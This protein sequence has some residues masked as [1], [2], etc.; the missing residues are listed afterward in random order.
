MKHLL[1][2]LST[3]VLLLV[4]S[5][6]KCEVADRIVA[7]V[8][9]DIVTLREVE[10]FVIVEKQSRYTSMNEY[11]RSMELREK[12][13]G[14]IENLLI[15]Q[16]GRKLKIDV[17]D[18][19]VEATVE[20]IKKQNMISQSELKAQLEKENV[21]YED[22]LD[23]LKL[24]IMR[25]RVLSRA[26]AQEVNIDDKRIQ[27]YY[28]AHAEDYA[29]VEYSIQH[30]FISRQRK[31]AASRSREAW[32]ELEKGRSFGD[33]A[34]D[35]SD[36]GSKGEILSASKADLIPELRQ[37]LQIL[38]PG[39][40]TPV[41]QTPYGFHILKLIDVKKGVRAPLEEVK[42]KI[43]AAIYQRESEKR[44]KDYIGK[45]KSGA[46]IEVKI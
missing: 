31:D 6:A 46:Y 7:I 37:G 44:Y 40:H 28:D 2:A 14:F 41:I 25:N 13:D 26:I 43:K 5:I 38:M 19:D 16:Q 36:E 11:V 22:F 9:D 4:P 12:L 23:G 29:D 27:E 35:Y 32:Q 30:I 42:D 45:L 20:D 24:S 18:K 3:A 33:V 34:K 17:S 8:N 10:R 21:R 1:L 39:S 15:K